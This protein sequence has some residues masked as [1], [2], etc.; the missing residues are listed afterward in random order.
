MLAVTPSRSG[1][2]TDRLSASLTTISVVCG[3]RICRLGVG[4]C[5]R[6]RHLGDPTA[7]TQSGHSVSFGYDGLGRLP[8][9]EQ[10]PK[11]P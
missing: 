10:V 6:L 3:Q 7:A 5:I 9:P 8:Y 1:F 4:R 11:A 2:A